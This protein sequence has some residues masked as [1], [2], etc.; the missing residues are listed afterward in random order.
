MKGR[1][2]RTTPSPPQSPVDPVAALIIIACL[3]VHLLALDTPAVRAQTPPPPTTAAADRPTL[4]HPTLSDA[5]FASVLTAWPGEDVYARWGHTA[6][7]LCDPAQ[8]LDVTFNYGTFDFDQPWFILRFLRGQLDYTLS[9]APTRLVFADYL[10]RGDGF[11]EQVLDLN[12]DELNRLAHRLLHE[13]QPENRT[14]RYRFIDNNCTTKARDAVFDALD[15]SRWQT[16]RTRIAPPTADVSR[17]PQDRKRD[18]AGRDTTN[19]TSEG[20]ASGAAA[21]GETASGD[22][23]P[24]G[25][26][27]GGL[28]SGAGGPTYRRLLLR[29]AESDPLLHEGI[30][31]VFG[32]PTDQPVAQ[33]PPPGFLPLLFHDELRHVQRRPTPANSTSAKTPATETATGTAVAPGPPA[34]QSPVGNTLIRRE[35]EHVRP[36]PIGTAFQWPLALAAALLMVVA[37][38]PLI[39]LLARKDARDA[40]TTPIPGTVTANALPRAVR[41]THRLVLATTLALLGLFGLAG[42]VVAALW[43]LTEHDVTPWNLNLLWAWPTH[44][45]VAVL[46]LW[47]RRLTPTACRAPLH[48]LLD[49]YLRATAIW[50]GLAVFWWWLVPQSLPLTAL[51]LTLSL[52]ALAW[53]LA[54]ARADATSAPTPGPAPGPAPGLAPGA[55]PDPPPPGSDDPDS[56]AVSPAQ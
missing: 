54:D 17:W 10:T 55:A 8:G 35:I 48:R 34:Q 40:V 11:V 14:Y 41:W 37:P 27:S 1:S 51:L 9:T 32:L 18:I 19:V 42:C 47:P 45:P 25:L 49:R 29:Y 22:S 15:D 28:T 21:S 5:A 7:R 3:G 26:T 53:G 12:A 16:P 30:D 24:R 4:D 52:A 33:S 44:L 2:N 46:L 31:L 13:L 43:L 38:R 36:R 56:H 20:T 50:S 23:T 6:I 39:V